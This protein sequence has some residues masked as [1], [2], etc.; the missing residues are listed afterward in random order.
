MLTMKY[1][2]IFIVLS[3]IGFLYRRYTEHQESKSRVADKK[4]IR[5][6]LMEE[7]NKPI[8]WLF[9]DHKYNARKWSSFFSR[10]NFDVNIPLMDLT[11]DS[12]V[13]KNHED[14][15]VCF[16]DD[17]S[18]KELL[19]GWSIDLSKVGSPMKDK[20]RYR[21]IISLLHEYGGLLVPTSFLCM[22]SLKPI[23]DACVRDKK[24]LVAENQNFYDY[25]GKE[26]SMIDGKFMCA[27]KGCQ[28]LQEYKEY[29]ARVISD[30]YTDESVFL[31]DFNRWL[32]LRMRDG[33]I[34]PLDGRLV[35]TKNQEGELLSLSV[36]NGSESLELVHHKNLFGIWIPIEQLLRYK[37]KQALC[38]LS[39]GELLNS[40]SQLALSKYLIF[41]NLV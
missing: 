35:G 11:T 39:Q 29:L 3:L 15:H 7:N 31:N 22:K 25:T 19:P 6:Y 30:D 13:K 1:I 8:L 14:F 23:H 5:E 9:V 24:P 34:T 28:V 36:W 27:N 26:P 2:I 4:W 16:I 12:I 38:Y 41:V 40:K 21:G 20:I 18:F 32:S 37:D 17:H 10:G 33:R